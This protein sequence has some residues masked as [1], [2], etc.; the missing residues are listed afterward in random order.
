[1]GVQLPLVPFKFQYPKFDT[2]VEPFAGTAQYSLKYWDKKVILIEK[3]NVICD[4]WKWLQQCTKKDILSIRQ[5]KCGENTDDF[6]WDCQEQKDLVG[7][8]I[9]GAMENNFKT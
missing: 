5:L 4:L 7:F 6:E 3:Y 2:I 8:I 1:M 9:T